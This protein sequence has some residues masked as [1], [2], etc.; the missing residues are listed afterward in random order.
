MRK[1]ISTV[2]LSFNRK[3]VIASATITRKKN[4]IHSFTEVDVTEPRRLIKLH[5]QKTGEK[6]SFTGYIVK[7]LAQTVKQYPHFN[8][9]I[10]R[11]KQVILNDV[12]ISVLTEREFEGEKVPEPLG[13][14]QA[15]LKSY[16]QINDEIRLA[17]KE[18]GNQL[19]SLMNITWIRF[20]PGFLLKTFVRLADKNIS[21]AKKYGKVAITAVGMFTNEP[22]WFIPH[23]TATVLLTLGSI[24]KKTI[25]SED[26]NSEREFL[27]LTVSFDHNIVDGAPAARFLNQLIETIKS[28]RLIQTDRV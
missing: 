16:Q 5:F 8:S 23:G 3:M 7:C 18:K 25:C 12:T 17:Q 21:M 2:P 22:V 9:F 14:N 15:Q 20:I 1:G 19:G 26:K 11:N 24:V 13:I 28:G 10:K 6:L 4:T 27:C